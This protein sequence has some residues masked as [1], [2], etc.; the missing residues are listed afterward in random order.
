MGLIFFAS[1]WS[2]ISRPEERSKSIEM[3]RGFTL[4]LGILECAGALGVMLDVFTQLAAIGLIVH[5]ARSDP[6]E[7]FQMAHRFLGKTRHR[8][9][10]LRSYDNRNEL[11][12]R[13]YC[14]GAVRTRAY[15]ALSCPS[16][17]EGEAAWSGLFDFKEKRLDGCFE[18]EVRRRLARIDGARRSS[19]SALQKIFDFPIQI[20]G[21]L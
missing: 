11:G 20:P 18:R 12:N 13:N 21:D 3:S 15:R 1:G 14:W 8:R 7:I 2:D 16:R 9:L 6:E 17:A 5:N 10:E 19:C 4:F